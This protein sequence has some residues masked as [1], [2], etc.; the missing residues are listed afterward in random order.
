MYRYNNPY[1]SNPLLDDIKE[2]ASVNQHEKKMCI[3]LKCC[4]QYIYFYFK[5]CELSS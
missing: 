2:K 5:K 1:S 3:V 4:K